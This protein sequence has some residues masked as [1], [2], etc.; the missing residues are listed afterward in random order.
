MLLCFNTLGQFSNMFKAATTDCL[1]R[2]IK[3]GSYGFAEMLMGLME[4]CVVLHSHP[5]SFFL[6]ASACSVS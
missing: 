1:L 3:R 5:P 2:E 4:G 6:R